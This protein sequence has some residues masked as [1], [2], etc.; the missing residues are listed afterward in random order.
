V[1]LEPKDQKEIQVHR[2]LKETPENEAYR[3]FRGYRG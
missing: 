1:K 3:A 2:E